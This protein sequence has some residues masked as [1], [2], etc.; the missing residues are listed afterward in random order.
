[1]RSVVFRGVHFVVVDAMTLDETGEGTD[2]VQR[3]KRE[4]DP[5]WG[6]PVL[7]THYPL[8]RESD[9]KCSEPDEA[10][11]EKKLAKFRQG[12]EAYRVATSN[13]VNPKE[14][15]SFLIC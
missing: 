14:T 12:V 2:L 1:V 10:P 3:V 8:F 9:E 6:R 13:M 4:Q 5:A 7:V 15:F 11:P